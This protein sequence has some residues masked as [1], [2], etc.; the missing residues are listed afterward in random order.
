MNKNSGFAY[1]GL[2]AGV[3]VVLAFG[4]LCF[5]VWQNGIDS[6]VLTIAPLHRKAESR[7]TN[8]TA[9]TNSAVNSNTN[10]STANWKTYTNTTVGYSLKYP[11]DWKATESNSGVSLTGTSATGTQFSTPTVTVKT[12]T[13]LFPKDSCLTDQKNVTVAG[14][15]R[16]RQTEGCSY[17][18]SEVAT[19]F[20]RSAGFLVVSWTTDVPS[21]YLTY[22][23]ILSTITSDETLGWKTYENT[24]FHF[25]I[26]HPADWK[27]TTSDSNNATAV[28]LASANKG[29]SVSFYPEGEFD[30][31]TPSYR[32]AVP[33][34]LG[35]KTANRVSYS[36][37]ADGSQPTVCY[38]Q[39]ATV[40]ETGWVAPNS[41]G[42]NGNRI[43]TACTESAIVKTMLSTLTFD[44]TLG[45]TTYTNTTWG[46]SFKY[47][48]GWSV[49][50]DALTTTRPS[51]TGPNDKLVVRETGSASLPSMTL[52]VDV[53]G[54]GPFFPN[55][56]WT[57][58]KGASG[59]S[60]TKKTT[61]DPSPYRDSSVYSIEASEVSTVTQK[62][63]LIFFDQKNQ[64]K[65]EWDATVESV[66]STFTFTQ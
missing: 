44:E 61:E 3:V 15:S 27:V 39:F 11:A 7:N 16:V 65:S 60:V 45:W 20:P 17:A 21:Q 50:Q 51:Y 34:T 38:Y 40:P 58:A 8:S 55:H 28:T 2:I 63:F 29:E 46:F 48:A 56:I 66:L 26:K 32:A 33:V 6:S 25:S 10:V 37:N 12:K 64:E 43:H 14:T 19:F 47:P 18:G 42:K 4:Y 59:F 41:E 35:G 54:F 31:G 36:A 22:E 13:E 5:N 52:W 49:V 57:I 24:D 1:V 53:D 30:F 23:Q 62:R 9:N